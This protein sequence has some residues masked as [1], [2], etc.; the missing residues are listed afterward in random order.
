MKKITYFAIGLVL[1]LFTVSTIK[2]NIVQKE[3]TVQTSVAGNLDNKKVEWGIKR[4][5]NHEQPD[6]GSKNKQLIDE[7]EDI[8]IGNNQDKYVYLS[9]DE[10]YE[11]GYTSSILDTLKANDV[12]AAFFITGHYLNTRV[13][14]SKK[15]DRRR[16]YSR[17]PYSKSL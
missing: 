16:S 13:R 12:K 15:N 8:A 7:N 9:F 3:K 6:L 5:D 10:G 2:S 11:A 4:A 14:I 1:V 17:K